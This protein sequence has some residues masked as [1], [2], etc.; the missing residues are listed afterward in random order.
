MSFW[1]QL[2]IKRLSTNAN[3]FF[4]LCKLATIYS[5][6]F[7]RTENECDPLSIF[8]SMILTTQ[9]K[10]SSA[11]DSAQHNPSRSKSNEIGKHM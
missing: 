4:S 5:R 9:L 2:N 6:W 10:G 3:I 7:N 11:A 8:K 1:M